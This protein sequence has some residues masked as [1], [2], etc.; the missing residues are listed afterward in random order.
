LLTHSRI[1]HPV[2]H[3][4]FH[5]STLYINGARFNYVYDCGGGKEV[6]YRVHH[7][8]RTL[9][10]GRIDAL[11]ISH[12]HRD[13]VS[14]L[15]QLLPDV[16]LGSVYIPYVT[17][18]ELMLLAIEAIEAREDDSTYLSFLDDPV[19]WLRDRGAERVTEIRGGPPG[20][21]TEASVL[22]LPPSGEDE[23]R[24]SERLGVSPYPSMSRAPESNKSPDTT[25]SR[26][27]HGK[28]VNHQTGY[29]LSYH[30]RAVWLLIPFVQEAAEEKLD[31]FLRDI[32][33]LLGEQTARPLL[34]KASRNHFW[35][36]V[37][38]SCAF[39]KELRQ[40]YSK[41]HTK[42]NRTSLCLY[43]GCGH[44]RC[45]KRYHWRFPTK[46]PLT[47]GCFGQSGLPCCFSDPGS[48]Y[49]WLGTGDAL[50][51]DANVLSDFTRH[52]G[53]LL[54]SV[55]TLSLP[56]HGSRHNTGP[57]LMKAV[58][59]KIAVAACRQSDPS[60]PSPSVIDESVRIGCIPIQVTG[61]ETTQ[62]EERINIFPDGN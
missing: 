41:V 37:L 46:N 42:F 57:G 31:Q 6:K 43:S 3:G 34:R 18:T 59:P 30:Q 27:S 45:H 61:D 60:H 29:A 52:Y 8:L 33:Q 54:D 4:F 53:R 62:F 49:A 50:L 13:H 11:F 9:D 51:G 38:A 25:E 55:H 21:F 47:S 5:S 15:D 16:D 40:A 56:H 19:Q 58:N 32:R 20:D 2:G 10:D 36:E 26:R 28:I 17:D 12:F 7:Y 22:E 39:R 35:K 24:V 48:R 1:Q 23:H 44:L 14:G